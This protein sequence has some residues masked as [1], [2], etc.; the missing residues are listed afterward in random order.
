M[1]VRDYLNYESARKYVDRGMAKWMGF[2]ISEH[3]SALLQM[4]NE[5]NFSNQM[6]E[7]E[8]LMLLRQVY[9]NNLEIILYTN[10]SYKP[11]IGKII[12]LENL[13]IY[14]RTESAVKKILCKNIIRLRLLE[15]ES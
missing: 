13:S 11:Y 6:K 15:N 8:I 4:G 14:F 7:E 1:I 3:T 2:F 12:D 9:L 10:E 5:I